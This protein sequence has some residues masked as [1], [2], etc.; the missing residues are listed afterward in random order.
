M[1]GPHPSAPALTVFVKKEEEE[2]VCDGDENTTPERDAMGQKSRDV[3]QVG[4]ALGWAASLTGVRVGPGSTLQVVTVR[5]RA[6]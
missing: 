4:G 5:L 3:S 1:N 2:G 6:G